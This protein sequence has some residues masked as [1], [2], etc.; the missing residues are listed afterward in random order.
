MEKGLKGYSELPGGNETCMIERL[1]KK[2]SCYIDKNQIENTFR[3]FNLNFSELKK[4]I[5]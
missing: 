4:H 2:L 1:N 5:R 3:E